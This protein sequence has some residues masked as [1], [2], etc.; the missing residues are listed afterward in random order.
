M[1]TYP[2]HQPRTLTSVPFYVEQASYCITWHERD[3]CSSCPDE[4]PCPKLD[5]AAELLAEY[6]ARRAARYQIRGN[7]S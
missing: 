7:E 1:S 6:R 3:T 5:E 4:G 2:D